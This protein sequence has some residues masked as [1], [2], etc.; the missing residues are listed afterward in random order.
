MSKFAG[1]DSA[2]HRYLAIY[3]VINMTFIT[4][5]LIFSVGFIIS[6]RVNPIKQRKKSIII[7]KCLHLGLFSTNLF[8]IFRLQSQIITLNCN[9]PFDKVE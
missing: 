4:N 3:S 2:A 9:A 5:V 6:I 7:H 1:E 8:Q